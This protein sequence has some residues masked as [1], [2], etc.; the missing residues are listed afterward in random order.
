LRPI[1]NG[2]CTPVTTE[3]CL[4][5]DLRKVLDGTDQ[6]PPEYS[7]TVMF[8]FPMPGHIWIY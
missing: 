1:G 3:L 6:F 5:V 7:L 8:L 4:P 2:F